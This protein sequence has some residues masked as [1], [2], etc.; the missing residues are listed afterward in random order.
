[1]KH[2]RNTIE[3]INVFYDL[4]PYANSEPAEDSMCFSDGAKFLYGRVR[5]IVNNIKH[6][7]KRARVEPLTVSC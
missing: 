6:Y 3:I 7:S 1:M 2:L 4:P 5:V